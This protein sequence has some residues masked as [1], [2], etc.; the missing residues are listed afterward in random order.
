M[1]RS[2]RHKRL[3]DIP[4]TRWRC[5]GCFLCGPSPGRAAVARAVGCAVGQGWWGQSNRGWSP[6]ADPTPFLNEPRQPPAKRL[7]ATSGHS[8]NAR[9]VT[10]VTSWCCHANN[11][12]ATVHVRA[13]PGVVCC[14]SWTWHTTSSAFVVRPF[15]TTLAGTLSR[16]PHASKINHKKFKFTIVGATSGFA[17]L[18]RRPPPPSTLSG[19]SPSPPA[20]CRST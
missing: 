4:W 18:W 9:R 13:A 12:L 15:S 14:S 11:G 8:D 19:I 20:S 17:D 6:F 5:P 10:V 3:L 7:I 16:D 1:T 2:L